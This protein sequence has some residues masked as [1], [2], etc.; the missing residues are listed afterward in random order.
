MIQEKPIPKLFLISSYNPGSASYFVF[1]SKLE[2]KHVEY[3]KTLKI[4]DDKNVNK[5]LQ[6]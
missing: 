5:I 6:H 2:L 4:P 3:F 1:R